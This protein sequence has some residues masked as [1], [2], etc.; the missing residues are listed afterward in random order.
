VGGTVVGGTI[1]GGGG[2]VDLVGGVGS[3]PGGCP[4]ATGGSNAD[5]CVCGYDGGVASGPVGLFVPGGGGMSAVTASDGSGSGV[6]LGVTL[7]MGPGSTDPSAA[8]DDDASRN[9]TTPKATT[10]IPMR[11][12]IT[13][14]WAPKPG[15][16]PRPGRGGGVS[17]LNGPSISA[18]K[19]RT[20]A[21]ASA[22]SSGVTS[23][24]SATSRIVRP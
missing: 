24:P 16:I 1:V 20:R 9:P 13:S 23:L 11:T 8:G 14:L 10:T 18:K 19:A 15:V 7:A 4:D 2:D 3:R 17:A 12:P 22:R 21:R 6:R 5:V